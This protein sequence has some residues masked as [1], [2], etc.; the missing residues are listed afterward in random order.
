MMHVVI[1]DSNI[2]ISAF[3]FNGL[4]RKILELAVAGKFRIGISDAIIDEVKEVLSRTKFKLSPDQVKRI[5]TEIESLCIIFYPIEKIINACRDIEDHIIL[6]C[7]VAAN[8]EYI[9]TGDD[10]LL[11]MGKY[12]S[13]KIVN[14]SDFINILS[15]T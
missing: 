15:G 10:D 3:L 13:I 4:Q 9:V 8:A 1:L 7:A 14:S 2:F 5:I 12:T 11:S 6:E